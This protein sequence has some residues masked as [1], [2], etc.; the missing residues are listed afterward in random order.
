MEFHPG[1][2]AS[3]AMP[4]PM[5]LDLSSGSHLHEQ[6][7][8]LSLGHRIDFIHQ[9][10]NRLANQLAPNP[11]D[12]DGDKN[13]NKRIKTQPACEEGQTKSHQDTETGPAIGEYMSTIGLQD[14]RPMLFPNP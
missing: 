13:R 7:L 12:V 11:K 5:K 8:D 14:Q 2:I 1:R 3:V 9:P 6:M 4:Q 10:T